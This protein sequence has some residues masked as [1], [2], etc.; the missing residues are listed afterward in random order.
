MSAGSMSGVNCSRWNFR[1]VAAASVLSE[2]VLASPGTPSSRIWPLVTRPTSSRSTRF[3]WPTS[4]AGDF[5]SQRRHP[6]GGLAHGFVDGLN[7]FVVSAQR[8]GVG[9][10]VIN[11]RRWL[12]HGA[13]KRR[14]TIAKGF[15]FGLGDGGVGGVGVETIVGHARAGARLGLFIPF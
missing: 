3:F 14:P 5:L 1:C 11:Y 2:S 7:A 9:V 10:S 13:S 6:G 4:D 12:R 8:R 15:Q